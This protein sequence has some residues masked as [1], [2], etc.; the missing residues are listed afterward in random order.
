MSCSGEAYFFFTNAFGQRR[1]PE[2][3]TYVQ[4]SNRGSKR[5]RHDDF[6]YTTFWKSGFIHG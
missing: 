4:F 1:D 3:N 6:I 2:L 5:G